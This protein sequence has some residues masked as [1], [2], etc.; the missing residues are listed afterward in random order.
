M[1]FNSANL[2]AR[3]IDVGGF[4]LHAEELGAGRRFSSCTTGEARRERG[5][6]SS[7]TSQR[8]IA[9]LPTTNAAAGAPVRRSRA[10]GSE[11]SPST[12]WL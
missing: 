3:R 7:S 9:A 10:S 5:D 8:R 4:T 12:R 6:P 2:R 11:T 1:T